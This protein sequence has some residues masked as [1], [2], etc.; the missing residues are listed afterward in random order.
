MGALLSLS[1]QKRRYT[2]E[3]AFNFVSL[4]IQIPGTGTSA[5][6]PAADFTDPATGR[7]ILRGATPTPT[8]CSRTPTPC[9]P[10]STRPPESSPTSAIGPVGVAR[11]GRR[12]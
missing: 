7:T 10:C 9:A 4:P 12:C 1:Y 3:T 11:E 5:N 8:S 2:D 6:N